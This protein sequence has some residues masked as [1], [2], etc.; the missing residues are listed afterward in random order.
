MVDV[1]YHYSPK[2]S[3]VQETPDPRN[4]NIR[5]AQADAFFGLLGG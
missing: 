2:D 5:D 3:D 4:S 1:S